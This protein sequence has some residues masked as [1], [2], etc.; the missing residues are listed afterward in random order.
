MLSRLVTPPSLDNEDKKR[1]AL[2]L[3]ILLFT[4][5]GGSLLLIV[6]AFIAGQTNT[7]RGILV[8]DL[9]FLGC[10]WSIRQGQITIPSVLVPSAILLLIAYIQ[11]EGQGV[12]DMANLGYPLVVALAGLLLGR[13]APITFAGLSVAVLVGIY[14]LEAAGHIDSACSPITSVDDILNAAILLSLTGVFM[15]IAMSN[16][17]AS[18]ERVRQREQELAAFNRELDQRV[19]DRTAQLETANEQLQVLGRLKDEFVSNVSHELRTPIANIK[20]HHELLE[21]APERSADFLAR[22]HRETE[23]L[24]TLI[25][26][27]LALS[28]LDQERTEFNLQAVDLNALVQEHITD[29]APLAQSKG[30]TLTAALEPDL[31]RVR[32]DPMLIGQVLSILLTNAF[33]Y[34]PSGEHVRLKTETRR[35]GGRLWVGCQVSDTGPGISADERERVFTRF[36]RGHVGRESGI[37]GTGLGLA[38]AR[39]IITRHQGRIEID[40]TTTGTAFT[41]WLPADLPDPSDSKH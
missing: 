1:A 29:R 40:P 3:Y 23:R 6:S 19:A 35:F 7:L 9:F 38:I 11:F 25:E 31:P 30:L 41:I 26:D 4:L 22:L 14:L 36:F 28:R 5:L 16:L 2:T 24:N 13:R 34:T 17:S 18:L 10:L 21:R 12:H 32:V 20:L 33:N 8:I 27:M 39:E 37:A 15:T